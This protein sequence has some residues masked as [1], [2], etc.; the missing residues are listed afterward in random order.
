MK[1]FLEKFISSSSKETAR[2][3]SEQEQLRRRVNA[4]YGLVSNI[5]GSEKLVLR[6]GKL[7]ILDLMRSDKLEERVLALQKLV[8][9]KYSL[10]KLPDIEEIDDILDE[11]E[12]KIADIIAKR[13]IEEEIE[14]KINEKIQAR[15][16]EYVREIKMQVL[17]EIAGPENAQTLKKLDHLEKLEQKKLAAQALNV[18]R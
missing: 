7:G 16:E 18:L 17:K 2:R 12:D 9:E 3:F 8:F 10:D 4:L 5:Y 13:S 15:H 6:A 14:K 11:I 1:N